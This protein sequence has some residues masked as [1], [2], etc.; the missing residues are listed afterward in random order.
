[1]PAT[2]LFVVYRDTLVVTD[3]VIRLGS[4]LRV[5][6]QFLKELTGYT[7]GTDMEMDGIMHIW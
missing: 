4:R 5:V 2:K 1:M 6:E 7:A 3:I